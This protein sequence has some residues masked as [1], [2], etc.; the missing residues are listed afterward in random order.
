MATLTIHSKRLID[1]ITKL[2]DYLGK[3]GISWSLVTKLLSGNKELLHKLLMDPSVKQLHSV[4]DSRLSNLKLIKEIKPDIVTMYIKPSSPSQAKNLVKYADISLNTSYNTIKAL[5]EESK[6]I[7]KI[8][9]VVIMLEMGELREGVMREKIMEFYEKIFNLTN[10]RVIGLGTN[11]GCMVGIE[12][13]YDKLL[14]LS[15]YKML[16]E[17]RFKRR[18]DLISAGSSITLPLVNRK[19]LPE[20]VNHFRV[21]ETAYF[22]VELLENRRF[23]NLSTTAF[24]YSSDILEIEQKSYIP[25]GQ[26]SDANIGHFA[27]PEDLGVDDEYA[28]SFRA[29]VDFG[30]LDVDVTNLTPKDPDVK[31]FGV[32]SDMTVYDIGRNKKNYKVGDKIHFTPNYMAVA[33]LMNSKYVTKKIL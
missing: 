18:L 10:I 19:N 22:G 29:I 31:F 20:G 14:Q 8:H 24:D 23:K 6:K 11:L 33:R 12:P 25:D 21:G 17:E 26:Q 9:R 28:Q 2:N 16:L 13:T 4:G 32:S 27:S 30:E 3:Q 5:N 7:D 1:N 15:L